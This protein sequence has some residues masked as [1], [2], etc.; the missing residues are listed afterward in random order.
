MK[1]LE[2]HYEEFYHTEVLDNVPKRSVRGS[3]TKVGVHKAEQPFNTKN[4]ALLYR[5][6]W[7]IHAL[8]LKRDTLNNT[9]KGTGINNS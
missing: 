8:E 4:Y 6:R 3:G 1:L 9:R 7:S 2:E 5:V